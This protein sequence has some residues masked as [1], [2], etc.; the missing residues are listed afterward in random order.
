M[1]S[2][3]ANSSN[4]FKKS[5]CYFTK[6][7]NAKLQ[8]MAQQ[9]LWQRNEIHNIRWVSVGA[10]VMYMPRAI[11]RLW[12]VLM[13]SVTLIFFKNK[14]SLLHCNWVFRYSTI[15]RKHGLHPGEYILL[16]LRHVNIQSCLLI[17]FQYQPISLQYSRLSVELLIQSH[18]DWVL[19]MHH[20]EF[21]M[22]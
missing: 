3:A 11:S 13:M 4:N 5:D 22:Q 21:P 6:L 15:I 20:W 14:V 19:N 1:V 7:W 10:P 8:V 17:I 9:N 18:F 12:C 16:L 2:G